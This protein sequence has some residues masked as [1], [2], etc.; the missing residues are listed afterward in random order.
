VAD[1][2]TESVDALEVIT[3]VRTAERRRLSVLFGRL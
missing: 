1:R 3:S 2:R